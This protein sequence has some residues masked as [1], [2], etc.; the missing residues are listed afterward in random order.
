M[1][2]KVSNGGDLGKSDNNSPTID[3]LSR[4][5][6][7]ITAVSVIIIST[8]A[9]LLSDTTF[10]LRYNLLPNSSGNRLFRIHMQ[11]RVSPA[12]AAKFRHSKS[13]LTA[14]TLHLLIYC[15]N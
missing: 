5:L 9:F 2:K 13:F 10:V 7:L 4:I 1:Q 6:F 8:F 12:F 11:I 15:E 14:S 3:N